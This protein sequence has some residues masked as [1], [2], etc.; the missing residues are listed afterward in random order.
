M[1]PTIEEL[2]PFVRRVARRVGADTVLIDADDRIQEAML[3]AWQALGRYDPT[4]GAK[5][6]TVLRHR[7]RGAVIDAH[8]RD[9]T[10]S[11]NQRHKVTHQPFGTDSGGHMI[12]PA[13]RAPAPDVN[14]ERDLTVAAVRQAIRRLPA[15]QQYVIEQVDLRDRLLADVGTDVNVSESRICQVRAKAK[16]RLAAMPELQGFRS[17]AGEDFDV[18]AQ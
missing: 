5:L 7:V 9:E 15:A 6:K 13:D 14:V 4:G 10:F 18:E 17:S 12:E 8:R 1:T 11:R 3:A 2:A 16:K